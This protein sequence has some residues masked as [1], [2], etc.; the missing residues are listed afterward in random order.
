MAMTIDGLAN[1]MFNEMEKAYGNLSSGKDDTIAY[2]KTIAVLVDYI[3][4]NA[5]VQILDIDGQVI[6]TGRII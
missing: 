4:A 3:K 2:L 1:V 6:S 5:E